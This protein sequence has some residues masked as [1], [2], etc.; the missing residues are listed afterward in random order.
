MKT[1]PFVLLLFVGLACTAPPSEPVDTR[2]ST[3]SGPV[4]EASKV[5]FEYSTDIHLEA[6]GQ[7][8]NISNRTVE[9]IKAT[10][11]FY[12]DKGQFLR[13]DSTYLQTHNLGPGQRSNYHLITMRPPVKNWRFELELTERDNIIHVNYQN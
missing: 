8:K 11:S 6:H 12:D 9:F 4:L 5:Q 1:L 7:V 10:I 3:P 13:S 2:L